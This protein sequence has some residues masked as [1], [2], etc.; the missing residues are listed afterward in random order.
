MCVIGSTEIKILK[1]GKNWRENDVY[2]NHNCLTA[3]RTSAACPPDLTPL[4]S[5]TT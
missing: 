5:L 3:S 1:K 2:E 4:H